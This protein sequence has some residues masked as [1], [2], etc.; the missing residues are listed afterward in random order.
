VSDNPVLWREVR[1]PMMS[2]RWQKIAA[3]AFCVIV[4]L[5]TYALL[6]ADN[7]LH[8]RGVQIGYAIV[9]HTLLMLVACVLSATAIA[10][11]KES[12]T[13]TLLLA[14]P[15]SAAAIVFGK[16]LGILRRL[17]WPTLLVVAHFLVFTI[18]GVIPP[19]VF[20]LIIFVMLTFNTIWVASGVYLSMRFAK[21][22]TAV[23]VNLLLPVI[24]YGGVSLSLAAIEGFS[25]NYNHLAQQVCWYLPYFWLGSGIDR[26]ERF[27]R[28]TVW[29]PND[30]YVSA[31][32]FI[33]TAMAIGIIHIAASM[34]L[35]VFTILRFN[36]MVGRA[37]QEQ[38]LPEDARVT[39]ALATG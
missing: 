31:G 24:L 33:F 7:D 22:T 32:S 10:Q 15:V 26:I 12:D 2:R 28:D 8:D 23:M 14:T 29:L 4:L 11:E 34:G 6:A 38:P 30:L 1:R 17:L 9:M 13:W 37:E 21:V 16:T 3:A 25:D 35:L 5:A 39:S 36:P 19:A 27:G 18:S 20:L